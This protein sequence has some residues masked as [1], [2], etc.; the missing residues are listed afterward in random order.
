[1]FKQLSNSHDVT[2]EV[3][4]NGQKFQVSQGITV[5]AAVLTQ[6]FRYT[7]TTPVSNSKRMPFCMM[8]VCYDCLMVIDGKANQRACMTYVKEGM[9]IDIQQGVGSSLGETQ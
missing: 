2:V 7:R 3:M 5:A 9:Q 8:G 4:L 6:G 1:M